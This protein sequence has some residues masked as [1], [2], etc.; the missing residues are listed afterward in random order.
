MDGEPLRVLSGKRTQ[1]HS[2]DISN[3]LL[4]LI[5]EA[6]IYASKYIY[7]QYA[8]FFS[9]MLFSGHRRFVR[10]RGKQGAHRY[11]AILVWISAEVRGGVLSVQRR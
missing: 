2:L 7:M 8:L 3:D 5:S 9:G 4:E 10:L 1:H 11:I 6:Y